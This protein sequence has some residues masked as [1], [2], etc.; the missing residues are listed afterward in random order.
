MLNAY[1]SNSVFP[2]APFNIILSTVALILVLPCGV[3]V[4]D[5]TAA[6]RVN[7][8]IFFGPL[9][10]VVSVFVSSRAVTSARK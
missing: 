4:I 1:I 7:S 9:V 10:T 2:L 3:N 6:Y 8:V 5:L